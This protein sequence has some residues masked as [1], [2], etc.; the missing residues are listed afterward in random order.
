MLKKL[1][2][3]RFILGLVD[4]NGSVATFD[5]KTK[6]WTVIYVGEFK[7]KEGLWYGLQVGNIYQV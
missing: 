3:I 5:D 2:N 6:I 4:I 1:P 7:L